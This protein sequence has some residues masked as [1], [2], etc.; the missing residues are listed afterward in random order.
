ML[1]YIHHFLC[2]AIVATSANSSSV[3]SFICA[4]AYE[5]PQ[6]G[7]LSVVGTAG[8]VISLYLEGFLIPQQCIFSLRATFASLPLLVLL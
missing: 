8:P 7:H 2:P 4:A 1:T 5:I 6:Y 3:A